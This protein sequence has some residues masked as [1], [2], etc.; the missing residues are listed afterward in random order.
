MTESMK[1][2]PD[3]GFYRIG[4]TVQ[5]RARIDGSEG[6]M[7]ECRILHLAD[8]VVK[9]LMPI[10]ASQAPQ[11]VVV[12]WNPP[13]IVS[14]GYGVEV[15]HI[16][17]SGVVTRG[18]TAFD[19][20]EAWTSRPRYGFL[21]DFSPNRT[22]IATTVAELARFHINGVQ[23][24][25]WH[26]RHDNPLPPT[27]VF[28]DPLGRELSIQ[29]VRDLIDA[30]SSKGMASMAY[31]AVYGAS[32]DFWREKP[33]WALCDEHGEPHIFE[34]DFLGLMDPT[35]GG[36]WA[37]HLH[38]RCDEIVDSLP[39]A[40][41]HIDQYGEPRTAFNRRGEEVNLPAAFSDFVREL[42]RRRPNSPTTFNAV[43]NWPIDTLLQAPMDFSYIEL[44]PDMPTYGDIAEVVENAY[45]GSGHKPVVI[46]LYLPAA[47]EV[48]IRLANAL[49]AAHGG[50]RIELGEGG[51]LLSDPYFPLHEALSPRLNDW[52]RRSSDFRVRYGELLCSPA[53]PSRAEVLV[54]DGVWTVVREVPGWL[55][56][57]LVNMSDIAEAR[58][59]E[60]HM[61]PSPLGPVSMEVQADPGVREVWA[62]SPDGHDQS[63]HRVEWLMH[64]GSV[65]VSVPSLEIWTMVAIEFTSEEGD[66]Q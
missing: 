28:L 59:D 19:V 31:V 10:A 64:D 57:N 40:G 56:I 30:A 45:V 7:L 17:P 51:R 4:E 63:L 6:G 55:V 54:P 27:E 35:N 13:D 24:Y 14:R 2:L 52:L 26:Y 62:A 43:K 29:T 3:K 8:E 11:D 58:W 50:S 49:I 9:L 5:I 65:R 53:T 48:N 1:I 25:D 34:G 20:L 33:E 15:E 18:S 21:S 66:G 32:M 61:P 42:K 16:E 22:D 41:I 12:R 39:F 36:G 38:G 46:A 37:N 23:F 47:H 60:E 44:W